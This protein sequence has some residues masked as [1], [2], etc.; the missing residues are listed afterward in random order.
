MIDTLF[1]EVPKQQDTKDKNKKI[2]EGRLSEGWGNKPAML[3][4][5]DTDTL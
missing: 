1:V 3:S 4:R 2:K 5:K